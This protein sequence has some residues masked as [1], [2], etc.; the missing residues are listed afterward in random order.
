MN[1]HF[2]LNNFYVMQTLNY[3][4]IIVCVDQR[5]ISISFLIITKKICIIGILSRGL[6]WIK[7]IFRI[8]ITV[9]FLPCHNHSLCL[10]IVIVTV[11]VTFFILL[12]F[13]VTQLP[14]YCSLRCLLSLMCSILTF[15]LHLNL[16]CEWW[17]YFLD[18]MY[19]C[20]GEEH[21]YVSC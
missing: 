16:A 5:W 6:D 15:K 18:G 17:N 11:A 14:C 10:F 13:S 1:K 12:N 21:V 7:E 20:S 8:C 9:P 3:G 2:S 4:G 19:S